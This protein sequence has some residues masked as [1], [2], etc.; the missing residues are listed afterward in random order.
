MPAEGTRPAPSPR[1][2]YVMALA[3]GVGVANL[4]FPQ[5]ITPLLSAAFH[6]SDG[7]AAFVATLAQL[8]YAAGVFLL[9]PLGDRLPRRP[10]ITVL[11]VVVAAGLF[12]A[13][14]TGSLLTLFIF[15]AVVGVTTVVPQILIPMAAD[16]AGTRRAGGAVGIVQG[17]LLG[18]VL[19]SRAF[20]GVLGQWLGWR[21]PYLVSGAL[22][23]LLAVVLAVALPTTAVP[24]Q[25]RYPVLLGTSVQLFREQPDLR[26]SCLYQAALFGGF[27]AAWTSMALLI[28]GP[29]YGYGTD[30]VG[31]IA[32]VG[33]VSVIGV[34]FAGR[35]TD[36]LG[37]DRIS[38]IAFIGMAASG[39][40]LLTG[41]L[42]GA[43][44]LAGLIAG[45]LLLDVSVQSSQVA[46]QARI[47]A[48][49]P[50]ARS[51]LNSTYLTCVF[52]GG[53]AGSWVGARSYLSLGWPGVCGLVTAAGLIALLRHLLRRPPAAAAGA[54]AAMIADDSRCCSTGKAP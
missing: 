45:L 37:P 47:F 21:A 24:S 18:G 22:A 28:T 36:R 6:V 23:V 7:V 27:T 19:L 8:G 15:S 17:G 20:G 25:H 44:G 16:L 1:P 42:G 38:R 2:I 9:V 54:A 43:A 14:T 52:L 48:L 49:V 30:V 29:S 10:L 3:C 32:L 41:S 34:P 40:L 50:G 13:G 12:L 26:R 5:A 39:A 46:N 33:A 53:S 51:R 35:L 4:Y 11:F 31:L